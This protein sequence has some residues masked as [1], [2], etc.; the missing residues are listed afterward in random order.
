MEATNR[1]IASFLVRFTQDLW[2]DAAGDPQVRWQGHVRHVQNQTQ[3]NFTEVAEAISF[4][5]DELTTLTL[6]ALE[7]SRTMDR[8]KGLQESMK[9]WERFANSYTDIV[10]GSVERGLAQSKALQSQ[11]DDAMQSALSAW[12]TQKGEPALE[13]KVAALES[14]VAALSKRLAALENQ[15]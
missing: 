11:I 2:Q 10:V 5:Q 1:N 12:P 4:M 3:Q 15:G 13:A 8:E 9:L 6:N 14:E 7:T